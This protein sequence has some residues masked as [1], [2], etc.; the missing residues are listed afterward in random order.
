MELLRKLFSGIMLTLLLI[1]MLGLM[2]NI[3]PV[4]ASGTIYIRADG[5]IDPP[6]APIQRDGDI[7]TFTDN[8][9]DEIVVEKSNII[10]DGAGYTLQGSGS[11]TGFWLYGM[12]GVTIKRSNIQGFSYGIA[13]SH[14]FYNSL[15]ENTIINCTLM[16]IG[17]WS[18]SHNI[19]S[20]NSITNN[21]YGVHL[22]DSQSNTIS[23]NIVA[24]NSIQGVGIDSSFYNTL[25]GNNI[26]NNGWGESGLL[27][28]LSG[29]HL[30][31]SSNNTLRNNRM[32]GNRYNFMVSGRVLSH[33]FQD[34]DESNTVNGKSIYYFVNRRNAEVPFDAGYVAL[35]QSYNITVKELELK[36]NGHGILLFNT[37]NSEITNNSIR[38]N[39]YGVFL[40][41]S[42]NNTI[43]GNNVTNNV[44]GI[45]LEDSPSNI[46][47]GNSVTNN[48]LGI[49][50]SSSSNNVLRN[51]IIA[52]NSD[53]F[54]VEGSVLLDFI[55]D[56]DTS[57][58]VDGKPIYYWINRQNE[59]V[60][61]SAGYVTLVNC[62][63][64]TVK[65]LGLDNEAIRLFFT[66]NST[67]A[68]NTVTNYLYGDGG[69]WVSNSS[70]N[71]VYGNNIT[72]G[73]F[74][75]YLD[76][77]SYNTIYGNTIAGIL[78]VG[79]IT[80]SGSSYNNVHDN[81]ITDGLGLWLWGSSN[82]MITQNTVDANSWY[83]GLQISGSSNNVI[84]HN[85]FVMNR[86]Q[87]YISDS[88]NVWDDSYP[89]GGNFWSNYT[90]IDEFSGPNQ[91]E[92]GS[93]GIGDTP[94]IIDEDNQDRYPL[95]NPWKKATFMAS[96][97]VRTTDD[98]NVREG[99]GL[100]Y[101][102]IDTMIKGNE[103]V[104]LSGPIEADGYNWWYINYSVGVVGWSAEN[105][106]ELA[107]TPP[108]SPQNFVY[109]A[110]GAIEWAMNRLGRNDW[111]GLCMRF[112]ANAFMQKEHEPAGY[113]AIDGAREFY[114]FDQDPN[115]WLKAPKGALIF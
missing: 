76:S 57:N 91:D 100:S 112:V 33:F 68:Q 50:L 18:S 3:Q 103:G 53:N 25:A 115:G 46:L 92:P 47:S 16:G 17:V 101:A 114:R 105:W 79:G 69:I 72:N 108:S 45:R 94:Y 15:S 98:L 41:Y 62:T 22:S 96:D 44:S 28:E 52:D 55:Q 8:I 104:V 58:T 60:S 80:L 113:N 21:K 110:E 106:L 82:N 109:W 88:V 4:K 13:L 39:T 89:S 24:N 84:Y 11:G 77:S 37:T 56:V 19:I 2:F 61:P 85:N 10:I 83:G 71:N 49:G 6:T 93:D 111:S 73:W 78:E 48:G 107:P 34:V 1:S 7:Y 36:N 43:S 20:N 102:V 23:E 87:I 14:S 5:S 31:Y 97:V 40:W 38:N 32:A 95:M 64:I 59:E 9:Y 75:I 99:P 90:G 65:N 29:V 35:V 51:N 27:E 67:I 74:G 30:C 63:N 70:N 66:R 42:S 12:N 26:I 81:T 86:D 54:R